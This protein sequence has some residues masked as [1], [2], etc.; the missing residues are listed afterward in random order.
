MQYVEWSKYCS[1]LVG[2]IYCLFLICCA[3]HTAQNAIT[4]IQGNGLNIIL[5]EVHFKCCALLCVSKAKQS[6]AMQEQKQVY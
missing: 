6:K 3:V 2:T 4:L 1:R 5:L